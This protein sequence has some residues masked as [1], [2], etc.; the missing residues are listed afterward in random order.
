MRRTVRAGFRAFSNFVELLTKGSTTSSHNF[1]EF[2]GVFLTR[3]SRSL[4]YTNSKR[5]IFG[6]FVS[7]YLALTYTNF[8][9]FMGST[10]I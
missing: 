1:Q 7:V 6:E 8:N 5:A 4:D 2:F 3:L 9:Y 10:R